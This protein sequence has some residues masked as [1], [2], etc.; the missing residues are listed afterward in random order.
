MSTRR[1]ATSLEIVISL[2]VRALVNSR[3]NALLFT[4]VSFALRARVNELRVATS[5]AVDESATTRERTLPHTTTS[6]KI[7]VALA[8][9]A[10]VNELRVATSDAVDE[11]LDVRVSTTFVDA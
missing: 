10:R 11:S 6:D 1:D 5:D 7:D 3:A 8:L 4:D 2:I 9:R